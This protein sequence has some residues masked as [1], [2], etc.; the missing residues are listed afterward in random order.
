MVYC[1]LGGYPKLDSTY[2]M[3]FV[4]AYLRVVL[5][6]LCNGPSIPLGALI[7][8]FPN[9][10]FEKLFILMRL[11][12][13][14]RGGLPTRPAFVCITPSHWQVATALVHAA[15]L[16]TYGSATRSALRIEYIQLYCN[17]LIYIVYRY[18][19]E[20]LEV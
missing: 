6:Y 18:G 7:R 8:L 15:P 1:S 3:C 5:G 17:T 16:R 9:R 2:S 20:R 10:P 13:K 19:S 12:S 11:L 4:S 14:P